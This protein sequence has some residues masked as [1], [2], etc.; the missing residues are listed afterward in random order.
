M[1]ASR[2]GAVR[3]HDFEDDI[4]AIGGIPAVPTILE[5]VCRT[6]GMGFAAVARVTEDRWVACEV[7][8]K[9]GFG[10]EPGGELKVE[11]TI[12]SEIRRDGI[13]VIID[14]VSADETYSR[15]PTPALYGFESYI[16]VPIRLL[17]GTF[18][19]TL[20]AIDPKP[21]RVNTP[22]IVGV[23]RMFAELIGF[24]LDAHRRVA[25]STVERDRA[26]RLS[27]DLLVV[28]RTNGTLEA[29]NAAWTTV[30]GWKER[31]LVGLNI[32]DVCHPAERSA[33]RTLLSS[34]LEAPLIQPHEVRLRHKDGG[35]RWFAWTAAFEDGKIYASG[36]DTTA[37]HEQA[38]TLAAT[39][40]AL[41]QSQKLEAIGQ[42]TGGVAHD[43]NNLLT[44]IKSAT[45]LLK[46]PNLAEDRRR[47]YVTAISDTVD[48]AS[49]LTGQLLAFARRQALLSEI[50]D[51]G[52][53]VRAVGE[54]IGTLM[55]S[56]IH[57]EVRVPDE[58]CLVNADASQFDTA[59]V[60]MAV[61]ARD[62]MDGQGH[63]II[64]VTALPGIPETPAHAARPGAFVAVSLTDTG[65][66]IPADQMGRIFEPFYTTK[67]IG[68]GTGLGL[69]QVFGFAKQS[70]GEVLV[71][72][73]VGAGTT[74]TFYLPQAAADARIIVREDDNATVD[75]HGTYV[76]V[77]EDNRD[78]GAF[79]TQ[80]LE[81]L[82][83]GTRW[84]GNAD[85]ALAELAAN[86][87]AFDVV[88]SD[89][90]M[91]GTNGVELGR[92]IQRRYPGLPIILTSGYSTVLSQDTTHGFA[93]LQKPYSVEQLSRALRTA[94]R[95]ARASAD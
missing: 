87:D 39:E 66:G 8:D 60:N 25:V 24:H 37:S 54:M 12:C 32:M 67:G 55:G 44:V 93:L 45:D 59:L 70:G 82:G 49:R 13:E 16:S 30:L 56:R 90:M 88:F 94:V 76:L 71:E 29:V 64:T 18:F 75:G 74:F 78:V 51:A 69:S 83:Y 91:P 72:S 63:L 46:R 85:E 17:N 53:S 35:Y 5:L 95:R 52:Q 73:A 22:E 34:I 43:F 6:T 86:R 65:S 38:A 2:L 48:R 28:G 14:Q 47:R 68:Q 23:F 20:C 31:E 50:F 7:H 11:T 77:V 89:V 21:A 15:H 4:L 10:L 40:E 80:T 36:R 58:P 42:L 81:E 62:A 57:L 3:P 79:S 84:V 19:G 33:L 1:S 27:Q 41:R 9:I 92:E 26:W 61:N